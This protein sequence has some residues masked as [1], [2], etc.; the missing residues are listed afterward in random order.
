MAE[1]HG[2]NSRVIIDGVIVKMA[3]LDISMVTR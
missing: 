2:R 1:R 3:S